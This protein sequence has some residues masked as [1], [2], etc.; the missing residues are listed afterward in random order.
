MRG[1]PW[2]FVNGSL[3]LSVVSACDEG[4]D[5]A[6]WGSPEAGDFDTLSSSL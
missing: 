5:Q 4:S 3:R 1:E 6:G 2:G